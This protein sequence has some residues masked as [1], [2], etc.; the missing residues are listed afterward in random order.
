M[1]S[2]ADLVWIAMFFIGTLLVLILIRP[3]FILKRNPVNGQPLDSINGT[4]LLGWSVLF[5]FVIYLVY[6][7]LKRCGVNA[8]S[9][10]I[11][12]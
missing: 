2:I 9:Q 3:V 5:T 4:K 1:I 7:L 12:F 6:Y 11:V 10:E 8:G